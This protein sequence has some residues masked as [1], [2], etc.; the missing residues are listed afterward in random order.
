MQA[1]CSEC[2]LLFDCANV[3]SPRVLG[4]AWSYEHAPRAAA[5]RWWRTSGMS[6]R[7]WRF[8]T[9]LRIDHIVRVGRLVRFAVFWL[10]LV[11]LLAAVVRAWLS[12]Y[13]AAWMRTG[14]AS[15]ILDGD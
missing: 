7:P 12:G 6:L 8:F 3:L 13:S 2:G 1:T 4:P 5:S 11:H 10:L 15:S 14:A 9:E